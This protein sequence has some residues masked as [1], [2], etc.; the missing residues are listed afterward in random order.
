[1]GG[2]G[3]GDGGLVFGSLSKWVGGVGLL[4][5]DC[6]DLRLGGA[7]PDLRAIAR[8]LGPVRRG[9]LRST[10]AGSFGMTEPG[11][12]KIQE[13]QRRRCRWHFGW[14]DP[15]GLSTKRLR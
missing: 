7:Y 2:V 6:H 15:K 12:F 5:P 14:L 9:K 3:V 1:M 8:S 4:W 13:A 10:V 11:V